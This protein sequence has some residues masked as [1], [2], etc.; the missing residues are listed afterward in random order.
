MASA[1]LS[2]RSTEEKATRQSAVV[3]VF[4]KPP[5]GPSPNDPSSLPLDRMYASPVA[6]GSLNLARSGSGAPAR[7]ATIM[8]VD[9][10]L[11]V[12]LPSGPIFHAPAESCRATSFS[13]APA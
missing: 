6:A 5:V 9:D 3:Y 13:A 12:C 10:G 7:L 4:M 1:T 2:V 8:A 11:G